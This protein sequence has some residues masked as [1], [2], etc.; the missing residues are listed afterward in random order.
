MHNKST[1]RHAGYYSRDFSKSPAPVNIFLLMLL[2]LQ[3]GFLFHLLMTKPEPTLRINVGTTGNIYITESE[4]NRDILP[5][6]I[7]GG[8]HE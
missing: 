5:R 3:T 6:Y 7:G 8:R 1:G 4:D 2:C